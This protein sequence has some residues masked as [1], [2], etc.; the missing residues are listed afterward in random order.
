MR[1]KD[2][3]LKRRRKRRKERLRERRRK[4]REDAGLPPLV[5]AGSSEKA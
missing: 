1:A 3:A 5:P 2:Q 4:A